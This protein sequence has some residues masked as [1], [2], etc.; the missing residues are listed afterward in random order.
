[1]ELEGAGVIES[2]P[3]F[4]NLEIWE[5]SY[6]EN[7]P[8]IDAGDPGDTVDPD[9]STRDIGAHWYGDETDPGDCNADGT[10]NIL[11]VVYLINDCILGGPNDCSCGDLNGDGIVNILDV[12]LLAHYILE[13]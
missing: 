5:F 11:D 7:S 8:C 2:N 3:L 12:V 6:L 10:Q 13:D 4:V 9:G 1:L